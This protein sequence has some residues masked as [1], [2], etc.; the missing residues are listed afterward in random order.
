MTDTSIDKL[1][2]PVPA[3]PSRRHFVSPGGGLLR[4]ST[5]IRLAIHAESLRRTP[6]R[7]DRGL[8]C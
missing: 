4:A 7:I 6:R 8:S 3:G 1:H 5:V 2:S